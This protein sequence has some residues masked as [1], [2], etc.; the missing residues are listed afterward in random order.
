MED[1]DNGNHSEL[2]WATAIKAHSAAASA[3]AA[4]ADE[5]RGHCGQS[6]QDAEDVL[7]H[8]NSL[9]FP[10]EQSWLYSTF[11]SFSIGK[12]IVKLLECG[13]LAAVLYPS[14]IR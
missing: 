1:L 9:H 12:M 6:G 2:K 10:L 7:F 11:Q 3:V 5:K 8:M 4:A 14:F 13:K